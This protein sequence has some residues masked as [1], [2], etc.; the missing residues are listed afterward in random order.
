MEGFNKPFRLL[1]LIAFSIWSHISDLNIS[2]LFLVNR[3]L[4]HR[5]RL[6]A[7]ER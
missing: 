5:G 3:L 7:A 1:I 2:V 6:R 4:T